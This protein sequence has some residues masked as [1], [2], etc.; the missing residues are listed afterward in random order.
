M[1]LVEIKELNGLEFEVVKEI[2]KGYVILNTNIN[3]EYLPLC[4]MDKNCY[5]DKTSLK[6]IR[7]ESKEDVKDIYNGMCYVRNATPKALITYFKK[8]NKD[9]LSPKMEYRLN[10]VF[11]ALMVL[12]KNGIK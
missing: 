6:C 3:S 8:Y 1:E 5:V 12:E 9:G 2:P 7:L 11:N 4:R 10:K